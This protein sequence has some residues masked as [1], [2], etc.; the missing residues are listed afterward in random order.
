M[1]NQDDDTYVSVSSADFISVQ[2]EGANVVGQDIPFPS[3]LLDLDR[4]TLMIV[5]MVWENPT[6]T[7]SEKIE[8]INTICDKMPEEILKK[9][10]KWRFGLRKKKTDDED[11]CIVCMSSPVETAIYTCGHMCMCFACG[12]MTMNSQNSK[13]PICRQPIKDIIRTFRS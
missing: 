8:S 11:E 4:N 10:R 9:Y 13:C 6:M 3:F 2:P 7:T 5:Q 12:Q 1:A